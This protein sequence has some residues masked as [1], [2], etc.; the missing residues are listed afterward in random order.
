MQKGV[1]SPKD[2]AS[3][4]MLKLLIK[5]LIGQGRVGDKC[6]YSIPAEPTDGSF[7][8]LYHKEI[9][10]M[11]LKKMGYITTSINEGFAIALSELLDE[12]LNFNCT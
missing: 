9:I 11:Y 3:L 6:V 7:D 8:V 12:G 2:K 4:P 1:I 5:S 10:S